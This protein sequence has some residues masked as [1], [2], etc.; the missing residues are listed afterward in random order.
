MR[1][2]DPLA[3]RKARERSAWHG[4]RPHV[5][6]ETIAS[7]PVIGDGLCGLC[8]ALLA[9][10]APR[11]RELV[12]LRVS[13][14]LECTY[15]WHGHVRISLDAVLSR[16]EIAGVAAGPAAF[17]GNDAVLLQAV[18][19]LL[20]EDRMRRGTRAAL[21]EDALAVKIAAGTYRTIAWVMAGIGP[22]P[23][24]DE[25]RGLETPARARET[26]AARYAARPSVAAQAGATGSA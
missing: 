4:K 24:L 20:R 9:T 25:V 12:A 26:Y 13:A 5:F 15:A 7:E 19:E 11:R 17:C 22:E 1:S 2:N 10:M 8:D 6:F 3:E 23:G 14:E 16:A 18:D 21:G